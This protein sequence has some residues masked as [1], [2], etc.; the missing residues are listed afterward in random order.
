[1]PDL[2]M[3][4]SRFSRVRLCVTPEMAA[5]QAP[6]SLGF[7]RQEPWSGLPFPSPMRES[8]KWKWSHSVISDSSQLHGL[9]PTRFL[10]PWAFPG[11]S[12]G[13]GCHSLLQLE[14]Q[15]YLYFILFLTSLPWKVKVIVMKINCIYL[16]LSHF[17]SINPKVLYRDNSG[18]ESWPCSIYLAVNYRTVE[19]AMAPHSSTLAWKIPWIEEPGRLQSMGLLRVGHDWATSLS[20]FTFMHW[21]RKWQPTRLPRP[22]DSPGKNPGVGCH[23]LLQCMKVKS[24]REVAQSCPTFLNLLDC[25]L[26]GSSIRGIFQARVLEGGAIAF[27]RKYNKLIFISYF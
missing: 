1:M 14:Y 26:P 24:E 19:K 11:K 18:H 5:R 23:F 9:Q 13:L 4:L 15:I 3:L 17:F 6:P 21:R 27:S 22:R 2:S 7:S 8:E 12:T 20:L 25:S 16:A 10:R